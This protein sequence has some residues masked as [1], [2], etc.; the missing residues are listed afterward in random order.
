MS[1]LIH[2][3]KTSNFLQSEIFSLLF[4]PF[5]IFAGIRIFLEYV[6]YLLYHSLQKFKF[7]FIF[8]EWNNLFLI[9]LHNS[10]LHLF[11][12]QFPYYH[13]MFFYSFYNLIIIEQQ[14]WLISTI[15]EL[16]VKLFGIFIYY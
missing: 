9:V 10:K 11:I 4:I 14:F 2:Q 15:F 8:L 1:M 7:F 6:F 16:F 13:W 3:K 12:I 5:Q